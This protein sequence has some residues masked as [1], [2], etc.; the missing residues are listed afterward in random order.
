MT[1]LFTC[2]ECGYPYWLIPDPPSPEAVWARPRW[3]LGVRTGGWVR[4][5]PLVTKASYGLQ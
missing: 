2:L 4:R 3:I 1:T 5:G